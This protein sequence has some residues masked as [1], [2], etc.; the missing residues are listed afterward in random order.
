MGEIGVHPI[1]PEL[2][3]EVWPLAEPMLAPAVARAAPLWDI[4]DMPDA[5]GR[6]V[7][8]LW[9][10]ILD[11]RPRAAA[12]ARIERYPRVAV[13]DVPFLGGTG[14]RDWLAPLHAALLDWGWRNGATVMTGGGRRGWCRLLGFREWNPVFLKEID[15]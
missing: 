12:L 15:G 9:L 5:I 2:L 4:A 14:M 7:F 6:R 3:P 10:V 13:L 11:G 8:D 1:R